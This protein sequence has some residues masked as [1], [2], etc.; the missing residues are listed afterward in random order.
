MKVDVEKVKEI[1][2]LLREQGFTDEQIAIAI[3]KQ[4]P[5]EAHPSSVS[6]YRW[7]AGRNKPGKAFSWAIIEI[8]KMIERSAK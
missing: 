2:N 3:G 5:G 6:V 4:M 7:R 1:L 8:G